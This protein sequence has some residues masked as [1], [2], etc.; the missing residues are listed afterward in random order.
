M[1]IGKMIDMNTIYTK[2]KNERK[3]DRSNTWVTTRLR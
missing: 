3:K 2:E 1:S